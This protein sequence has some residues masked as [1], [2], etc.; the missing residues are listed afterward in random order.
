MNK[1]ITSLAFSAWL[2]ANAPAPAQ[3]VDNV[4]QRITPAISYLLLDD[5]VTAPKVSVNDTFNADD[6]TASVD[7]KPSDV[8]IIG[9]NSFDVSINSFESPVVLYVRNS[10]GEHLGAGRFTQ[11]WTQTITLDSDFLSTILC[12]LDDEDY[13]PSESDCTPSPDPINTDGKWYH[14]DLRYFEW[15]NPN[16]GDIKITSIKY[17][18]KSTAQA[19]ESD[20]N[21]WK[22]ADTFPWP[23]LTIDVSSGNQNDLDGNTDTNIVIDWEQ[24]NDTQT[25][26]HNTRAVFNIIVR[27]TWK[28]DIRQLYLD[29]NTSYDCWNIVDLE[30][31]KFWNNDIRYGGNGDYTDKVLNSWEEI[32]FKCQNKPGSS[33]TEEI[34]VAGKGLVSNQQISASDTTEVIVLPTTN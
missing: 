29:S 6:N 12:G 28:Q 13:T 21:L 19:I 20:L 10:N 24:L 1:T 18:T 8:N 34:K 17:Q 32:N 16:T 3:N 14:F 33:Y 25:I 2:L 7:I 11:P 5:S 4:V 9:V 15:V 26:M 27:N 31:G 23:G 22:Y 30:N